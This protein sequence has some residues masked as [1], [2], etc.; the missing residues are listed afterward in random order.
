MLH[1]IRFI[2]ILNNL[3]YNDFIQ[4]NDSVFMNDNVDLLTAQETTSV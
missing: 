3:Y 2:Q 1:Y 4:I